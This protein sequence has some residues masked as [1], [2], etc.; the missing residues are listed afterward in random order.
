MATSESAPRVAIF[1]DVQNVRPTEQDIQN[2]NV[3]AYKQGTIVL[4]KAYSDFQADGKRHVLEK[5]CCEGF[6]TVC[7]PSDK[8]RP[9]RVDQRLIHDCEKLVAQLQIETIILIS[10][11][12]D[13][14]DLVKK[15]RDTKKRVVLICHSTE[16]ASR[17]LMNVVDQALTLSTI[18]QQFNELILAA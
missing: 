18:T 7:I 1:W 4:K 13:F 5:F 14:V 10:G 11:D 15:L 12:G 3:A 9:N 6:E 16:K 17:K 8:N 2:V